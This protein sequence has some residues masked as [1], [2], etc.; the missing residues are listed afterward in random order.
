MTKL[1]SLVDLYEQD[2]IF[3]EPTT[4]RVY[5]IG[6]SPYY[7]IEAVW[8][9]RNFWVNMSSKTPLADLSFDL[10]STENWEYVF[11]DPFNQP[12]KTESAP[13]AKVS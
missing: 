2:S 10:T 11:I 7:G 5:P 1:Q 9:H 12:P 8:N 13:T 3:I 4:G 6:L